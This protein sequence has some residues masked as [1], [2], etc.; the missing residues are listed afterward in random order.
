MTL[1]NRCLVDQRRLILSQRF[2]D[3]VFEGFFPAAAVRAWYII[4]LRRLAEVNIRDFMLGRVCTVAVL[5]LNVGPQICR[6]SKLISTNNTLEWLLSCMHSHM[7]EDCIFRCEF[8]L[9][10]AT[11]QEIVPCVQPHVPF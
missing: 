3:I 2:D 7:M 9:A 4:L 10:D 5:V 1:V 8:L 11:D 6:L